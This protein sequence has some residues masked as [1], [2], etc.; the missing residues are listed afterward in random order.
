MFTLRMVLPG[1]VAFFLQDWHNL[2]R[3]WGLGFFPMAVF[4]LSHWQVFLSI[5]G[6][7]RH[8][9][10]ASPTHTIFVGHLKNTPME[11]SN[12][13]V[14]RRD[15]ADMQIWLDTGDPGFIFLQEKGCQV[16]NI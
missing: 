11:N 5:G 8:C 9:P 4:V 13:S 12:F 3:G 1:L 10:V 16:I 2:E 15:S 14:I 6:K 7:S